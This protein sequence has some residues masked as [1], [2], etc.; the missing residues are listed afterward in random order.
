MRLLDSL[1]GFKKTTVI[2]PT[3]TVV[4]IIG[5]RGSGKSLFMK[6]LLQLE[7]VRVRASNSRN[8][9]ATDV[10]AE[11]CRFD[12]KKS[13]VVIVRTP[14]FYTEG[15]DGEE[16]LKKW[17]DS[18]Y[19]KPCKAVGVLCMHDL[20]FNAGDANMEVSKHLGAFRHT[21]RRNLIPSVIRAVPTLS[22]VAQLSNERIEASVTE[23]RRQ[24]NNE[25]VQ[26]CSTLPDGNPFDRKP[27]TAWGIVQELLASC[28]NGNVRVP[29]NNLASSVGKA[30]VKDDI[31]GTRAKEPIFLPMGPTLKATPPQLPS[32]CLAVENSADRFVEEFSGHGSLDT[33]IM[34]ERT[35]LESTPDHAEHYHTL[36]HLADLLND[37]FKLE[38]SKEDLDEVI[39]L[40]RTA[41][42]SFAPDDPQSQT[43]LLQLD[44][45]LYERFRR[46]D[47][48]ADLEEIVSLRRVL[49][50]RT[51]TPNRCKPLLNL[52]NSLH[53]RFQKQGL[54]EDI[55]EAIIL[56]RTLSE[57]CPPEHA[58][59]AQ[60][61]G[62]LPRYLKAKFRAGI[63]QAHPKRPQ[64]DP[65]CSGSFDIKHFIKKSCFETIKNLPPHLLHTPTGAMCNRK[66][67]LS[68]FE[69]S[70]QYKQL[71]STAHLLTEQQ[72]QT[73]IGSAVTDFF[74]I[75]MLSHRWGSDEP[76]LREIEGKKIYNLRAI[77]GLAKLQYFCAL[78]LEKNFQWAWSD[79]CCIDK[80][81]S[82]E[83][84]EAIG[85]MF[86]WYRRSS[87]TIVY[88]SDVSDAGSLA[89]SVWFQRG[90]TLQELLASPT[91]L[92]YTY[93]W[94]LYT[95][96]DSTNHKTDPAV[97]QELQEATG[98][99]KW[100]LTDFHPGVDDA[101]LRFHWASRRR[102]T[103][104]EDIAYSLFGI[105]EV[106]LPVLYGESAENALGRLLVEIISRSGDVSVLDW[107]GEQSSFNSCFPANLA[108]Y[109]V[110]P[111]DCST[112][113]DPTRR[114]A[115]DT[116]KARELYRSSCS[117]PSIIHKVT[118]VS[119]HSF[120]TSSSRYA[121]V[122]HASHLGPVNITLSHQLSD[123]SGAYILVRPWDPKSLETQTESDD[124]AVW[125]QLEQLTQPFSA[126]LLEQL[127]YNEYKR[128]ASDYMITAHVQ[129]L[130]SIL[131]TEV[132]VL[133][134]VDQA[135]YIEMEHRREVDLIYDV[136]DN[137]VMW[138]A[139]RGP[140]PSNQYLFCCDIEGHIQC[141]TQAEIE[142]GEQ[143]RKRLIANCTNEHNKKMTCDCDQANDVARTPSAPL[144]W[145]YVLT[146]LSS[147]IW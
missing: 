50:E 143:H 106:Q 9:D 132:L 4:F 96:N 104:P 115:L 139:R 80:D 37:R 121:Y 130:A 30:E 55:D 42:E 73:A 2:L 31:A 138:I 119:Q 67:Q 129:D 68:H 135:S 22:H 52:A 46:D 97:L 51:P 43:N 16:T 66:A 11:R 65:S 74:Q 86:S 112:L 23:F 39:A 47:A 44:D 93:D 83:L 116:A 141:A 114:S 103:R 15:S 102:T 29:R 5:P 35:V 79:T 41:L 56:A 145:H 113:N 21:C 60:S 54:V 90:W 19:T 59:Y 123:K 94:S 82:T 28:D 70:Y 77:D 81:S 25:G 125:E 110:I 64:I 20:A 61:R 12:G 105:F 58:E 49:L 18:N 108:P 10:H 89:S 3:D 118:N 33:I 57:L 92:F 62:C 120:S 13:D 111:Q 48:I 95:K 69:R 7:N 17:M 53:E 87:L 100:H 109:C 6:T 1:P 88:L 84:Q 142:W 14:S 26:F 136:S 91:V 146:V 140:P 147:L 45:C 117:M 131:D 122:I 40:R 137:H 127:H 36:I 76:L 133:G 8:P 75:A 72:L 101:R 124:E 34:F 144:A 24:A 98:I 27:E 63:A 78:A 99:A 71:L 134:I 126:L 85:S 32:S 107:V 38:G 128:I